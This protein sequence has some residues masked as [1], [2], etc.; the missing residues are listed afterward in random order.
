MRNVIVRDAGLRGRMEGY[1]V[2]EGRIMSEVFEEREAVEAV[3]GAVGSGRVDLR[4]VEEE[5]V[6]YAERVTMG[7][8]GGGGGG[9]GIEGTE[10]GTRA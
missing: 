1:W 3:N 9:G 5:A 7:V 2:A 10:T 4:A 8:D 6:R